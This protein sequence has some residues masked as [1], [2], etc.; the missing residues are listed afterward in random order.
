VA[1]ILVNGFIWIAGLT[2]A[3]LQKKNLVGDL[4]VE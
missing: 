2:R 4:R 1:L 3:M